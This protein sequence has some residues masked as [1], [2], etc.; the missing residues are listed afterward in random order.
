MGPHNSIVRDLDGTLLN[1]TR[2]GQLVSN[3]P[4]AV[5][6]S[7][8]V[9]CNFSKSMNGYTCPNNKDYPD[10]Y[11]W[12]LLAFES[13]DDKWKEQLYRPF[14]LYNTDYYNI[15][16]PM[17]D[18]DMAEYDISGDRKPLYSGIVKMK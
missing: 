17:M 9:D 16:T 15:F 5:N 7:A 6:S 10:T 8:G 13:V 1:G 11:E 18:T 12:K 4:S 3:N 14:H 2:K